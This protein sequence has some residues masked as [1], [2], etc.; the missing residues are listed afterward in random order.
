MKVETDIIATSPI[1]NLWFLVIMYVDTFKTDVIVFTHNTVWETTTRQ[2]TKCKCKM[3]LAS[4][5]I[6]VLA[7]LASWH[8][9]VNYDNLLPDSWCNKINSPTSIEWVYWT[10]LFHKIETET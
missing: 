10:W 1:E 5:S 8:V 4:I 3:I 7:I 2:L 9:C 6:Q